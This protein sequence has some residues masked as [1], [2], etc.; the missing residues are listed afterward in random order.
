MRHPL[1]VSTCE[2]GN[3][4]KTHLDV[5][6][7]TLLIVQVLSLARDIGES[8]CEGQCCESDRSECA[9]ETHVGGKE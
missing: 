2:R 9:E 4:F 6:P 7:V 3:L 1:P 8:C 5:E